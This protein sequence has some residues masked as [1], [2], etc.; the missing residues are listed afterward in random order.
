MIDEEPVHRILRLVLHRGRLYQSWANDHGLGDNRPGLL[1]DC[2]GNR[3]VGDLI[4]Q[5]FWIVVEVIGTFRAG[6]R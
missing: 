5:G 1:I 6:N 4:G 3:T 2:G